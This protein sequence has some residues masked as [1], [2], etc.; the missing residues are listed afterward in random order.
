MV[1]MAVAGAWRGARE[2][3][4]R[5]RLRGV[6]SPEAAAQWREA[7]AISTAQPKFFSQGVHRTF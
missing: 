3:E 2:N 5:G 1:V 4:E 7:V 6:L